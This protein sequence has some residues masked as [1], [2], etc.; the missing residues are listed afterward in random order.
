MYIQAEV[1]MILQIDESFHWRNEKNLSNYEQLVIVKQALPQIVHSHS[2]DH[3]LEHY[4]NSNTPTID[5]V[6][7]LSE[8][9]HRIQ[10]NFSLY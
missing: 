3:V 2:L 8:L 6:Y 9:V 10:M 4:L 7:S 5:Y 1:E